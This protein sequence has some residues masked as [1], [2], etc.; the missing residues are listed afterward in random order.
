[1]QR[2]TTLFLLVL[3]TACAGGDQPTD[4]QAGPCI[5]SSNWA[6]SCRAQCRGDNPFD[7]RQN[8]LTCLRTCEQAEQNICR[9][10][11]PEH[12]AGKSAEPT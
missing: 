12:G 6:A 11:K 7:G 4:S 10:A 5:K 8:D 9:P 3:L 1:M 2:F